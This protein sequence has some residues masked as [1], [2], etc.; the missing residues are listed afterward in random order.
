MENLC[1]ENIEIGVKEIISN[2]VD[3][4]CTAQYRHQWWESVNM[5]MNLQVPSAFG[6]FPSSRDTIRFSRIFRLIELVTYNN[7]HWTGFKTV[8]KGYK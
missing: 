3:W 6:N 4:I 8:I 7:L 2:T 1:K 5:V